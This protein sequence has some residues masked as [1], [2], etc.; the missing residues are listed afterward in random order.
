MS[1]FKIEI[2]Y[3][4]VQRQLQSLIWIWSN[5]VASLVIKTNK[6]DTSVLSTLVMSCLKCKLRLLCVVRSKKEIKKFIHQ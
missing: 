2:L 5:P 1:R 6:N 4:R 3:S